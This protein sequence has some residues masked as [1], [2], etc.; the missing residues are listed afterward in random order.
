M[1]LRYILRFTLLRI[2][3][4]NVMV[5]VFMHVELI[6][7]LIFALT[8]A[9]RHLCARFHAFAL[10]FELLTPDLLIVPLAKA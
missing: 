2:I 10:A 7:R 3:A 6:L 1:T 9:K 8:Q 5:L 4:R